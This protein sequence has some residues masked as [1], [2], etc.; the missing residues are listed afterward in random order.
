M[1]DIQYPAITFVPRLYSMH[2]GL[3]GSSLIATTCHHDIHY[4]TITYESITP[5]EEGLRRASP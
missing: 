5:S 3:V 4:A 2:P 1:H